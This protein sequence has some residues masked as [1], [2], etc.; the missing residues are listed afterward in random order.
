MKN[1]CVTLIA[2]I[3][4]A[5]FSACKKDKDP[6][7]NILPSEGTENIT[8]QGNTGDLTGA[9]AGNSVY[10]D[11]STNKVTAVLRS[12]WDLGFYCGNDFRVIIN[13]TSAAG[14]KVLD[15]YDL[16]QVGVQ[17]TAGL[18]LT[19]DPNEPMPEDLALYDDIDGD[20]SKTVIPPVSATD[21]DNPVIILNRGSGGGISER[22]WI[23]LR[24]LRNGSGYTLQYAEIE[25]TDFKILNVPKNPDYSFQFASIDDGMVSGEPESNLWDIVWTYSIFESD[26]GYGAVPYTF[27][28]LIGANYLAGV[29]VEQIVYADANTASLAYTAFNKDS[30]AVHSTVAGRWTIGSNWRATFPAASVKTDR[31]YLIKDADGNYYKFQAIAMGAGDG[32]VRGN[33]EFKYNLIPE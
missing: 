20:L 16:S 13:N 6:I 9:N 14:A 8:L 12:G 28:D 3:F 4:L 17:D 18:T 11:L 24:V 30:V 1:I 22:P 7:F 10:L 27:S 21:D 33:P 29:Q 25:E 26:F 19:F 31:F 15:K 2:I 5:G 32:G 23:K